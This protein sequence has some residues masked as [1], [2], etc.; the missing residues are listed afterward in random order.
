VFLIGLG[1]LP[2][3][4]ALATV[5]PAP[6]L[7]GAMLALFGMIGA[8]GIKMIGEAGIS[9]TNNLLIVACSIGSGL[10]VEAVPGLFEKL[11]EL[12]ELLFGNGIFTGTLI[13]ILLNLL[14]NY[15]E[16]FNISKGQPGLQ[17][18]EVAEKKV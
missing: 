16:I 6:V 1:V 9:S 3:F 11:P 7:G 5:V 2:K 8:T 4:S 17:L 13:A 10:G 18:A 15:N 12:I 14:F